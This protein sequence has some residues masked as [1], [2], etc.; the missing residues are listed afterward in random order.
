MARLIRDRVRK[1]K[2]RIFN[3]FSMQD[4]FMLLNTIQDAGMLPPERF[5]PYKELLEDKEIKKVL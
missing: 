4:A 3:K 2:P 1:L 5:K